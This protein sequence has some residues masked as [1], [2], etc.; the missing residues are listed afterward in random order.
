MNLKK[1]KNSSGE[2]RHISFRN[3]RKM[4]KNMIA[5]ICILAICASTERPIDIHAAE[6][7]N[8]E[9]EKAEEQISENGKEIVQGVEESPADDQISENQNQEMETLPAGEDASEGQSVTETDE[10][11]TVPGETTMEEEDAGIQTTEEQSTGNKNTENKQIWNITEQNLTLQY[12]DRYS[13]KSMKEEWKIASIKTKKILSNKVYDGK[14]T[15]ER[16]TDVVLRDEK[17]DT[18][19]IAVGVG[20]AEILL[21]PEK[22]LELAHTILADPSEKENSSEIIDALQINVTVE[23]ANLTLMYVAGQSNAEGS[24]SSNSGYRRSDSIAC[25]QGEIYSTYAPFNSSSNSIAGV[26]F[27]SFCR[28]DNAADFVAG[29]LRG[30][31]SIS[32]KNLEYKLDSLSVKGSGKTGPD[33]GLAYEWNRLTG[34]KVWVVNTAR[35]GTS[36]STWLPGMTYYERSMEVNRL[37]QQT[38]EAEIEAGH[39][40]PGQK[41]L[42]WLQGEAD[43]NKT[44]ESYY[45]SFETLYHAVVEN[46]DLDGFGIIMVRSNEGNKTNA[47]DISMSG[48]RIAQYAAGA[49]QEL[50]KVFIVSNVNEQWVSDAKVRSYFLNAYPDGKL[51]YPMHS[52]IN[53]LPASVSEIHSDIHYSQ[54]AHN[55]NGITAANGMY[56]ILYNAGNQPPKVCWKDRKGSRITSLTMG[57]GEAKVAVPVTDPVYCGKQVRYKVEGKAAVFNKKTGTITAKEQGTAKILVSDM[58]G[59]ILSALPITVKGIGEPALTGTVTAKSGIK[60]NWNPVGAATGYAV[61]RKPSGGSWKMIDTTTSTSYTDTSGMKNGIVYYYTVRAYKGNLTTAKNNKYNTKYWSG[62]DSSGVKGRYTS[63]PMISG[64]SASAAGPTVSWKAVSKA[65]GY[66]VYRR[67]AN[68][69]WA[70][71]ATTTSTSYTDK[72]TLLNGKTYYYTVRAYVG[73]LDTAQNYKY[74]SNYWSHYNTTGMKAVHIDVPVLTET[75]TAKSGIKVSWKPVNGAAGYTIYRKTA[76]ADWKMIDTT[77]STSYIDTGGMKNKTIYYTV[78]AYKGNVGTANKNKY[79][80]QYWSGYKSSGIKGKYMSAPALSSEKASASGRTIS[81]KSVSGATGYAVYRKVSG[82]NWAM[83]DTTVSTSYTDTAK[84]ENGKTYYYT[85]RAYCGDLNTAGSNKYDSNYW[86]HYNTTG[87]KTVYIATPDLDTAQKKGSGVRVTWKPVKGAGGYAIYRKTVGG[88]WKMIGM[89]ASTSYTD[90]K[91]GSTVYYTVRAYRGNRTA[92]NAHK[93]SSVYWSGYEN[94]GIVKE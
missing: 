65:A 43:K 3:S 14:S 36:I 39:Y 60:V 37:V 1:L 19:I 74:D 63:I 58:A 86:S 5:G 20:E 68:G 85:V 40:I 24:C 83:I 17:S 62:Y 55:E 34:D 89:T 21:V 57:S 30:S 42:F 9:S 10:K 69:S 77:T 22:Q 46:L 4:I 84:L 41:L 79:S 11:E 78:R 33:S 91:S 49:S 12:D 53:R 23:P 28:K 70:T 76:S 66:A 6:A 38:Y 67:D 94:K 81:W 16:D 45:D 18:D 71:I 90:K 72:S 15:D 88:S 29:S 26:S 92:A 13:F 7:V 50:S 44:A 35:G 48:P 80:A 87:L 47:D 59:N 25:N 73:G 61:Y 64:V 75:V 31:E 54:I 82:R 52:A 93:Y 27:S 8:V 51:T 56:N 32:G 2:K